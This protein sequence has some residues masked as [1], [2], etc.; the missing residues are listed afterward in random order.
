MT[1]TKP[2]RKPPTHRRPWFG[3]ELGLQARKLL[4]EALPNFSP[5]DRRRLRLLLAHQLLT[6]ALD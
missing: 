6:E 5:R 1:K 4:E 2:R 3:V